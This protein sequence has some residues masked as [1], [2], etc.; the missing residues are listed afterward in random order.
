MSRFR[1]NPVIN[2]QNLSLVQSSMAG[3]V[4]LSDGLSQLISNDEFAD[5]SKWIT[6]GTPTYGTITV[7]G[8]VCTFADTSVS[9]S[10]NMAIAAAS[11]WGR[12]LYPF[13]TELT[14]SSDA[15]LKVQI[16]LRANSGGVG[17]ISIVTLQN[18]VIQHQVD[19]G[20]N[21]TVT[22]ANFTSANKFRLM[23]HIDPKQKTVQLYI[24]YKD[25]LNSPQILRLEGVRAYTGDYPN[26]IYIT[27]NPATTGNATIEDL[28]VYYV[29]AVMIGDSIATGH[30]Y[31]DPVPSLYSPQ[32]KESAV[33][34]WL[35]QMINGKRRVLNQGSGGHS[36]YTLNLRY[37]SMVIDLQPKV[38]IYWIGSNDIYDDVDGD[39]TDAKTRLTTILTNTKAAGIRTVMVNCAPRTEF[40]AA[41]NILKTE[42]NAW[43]VN[44][45]KQLNVHL[46]DVH[47]ILA[48]PANSDL[49]FAPYTSDNCH[50]N[51][52]GYRAAATKVWEAMTKFA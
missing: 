51:T 27:S 23:W 28:L 34:Y 39:I 5:L 48:D 35:E 37:Q 1:A 15:A 31:Y 41:K 24:Y 4:D 16:E 38:A 40:V 14:F 44:I 18:N 32:T 25:T 45:C 11:K 20:V 36:T 22:P 49:I 46:A 17:S 52:Y 7:S 43:L 3:A 6:T 12:P 10:I 42:W 19:G 2:N 29:W 26:S 47:G 30:P 8:G 50:F 21:N 9:G 13:T 33:Q